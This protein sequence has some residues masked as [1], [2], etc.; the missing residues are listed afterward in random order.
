M[1]P[2]QTR[3]AAQDSP[4]RTPIKFPFVPVIHLQIHLQ[5]IKSPIATTIPEGVIRLK[6]VA[7][8]AKLWLQVQ[9]PALMP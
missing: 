6:T 7:L 1:T 3:S 8:K 9:I 5:A 4:N 2:S